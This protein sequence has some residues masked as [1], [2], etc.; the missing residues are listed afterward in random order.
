MSQHRFSVLVEVD[1]ALRKQHGR[2][3]EPDRWDHIDLKD[4]LDDEVA[5]ITEVDDHEEFE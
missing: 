5:V 1:D 3:D 2:L 4:A